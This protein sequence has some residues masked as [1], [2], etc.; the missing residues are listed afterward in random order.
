MPDKSAS[1]PF[2][3]ANEA[4][5]RLDIATSTV[6]EWIDRGAFPGTTR[7]GRRYRIPLAEVERVKRDGLDLSTLAKEAA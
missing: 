1:A 2:V 4:G 3:S 6:I 7:F 5:K